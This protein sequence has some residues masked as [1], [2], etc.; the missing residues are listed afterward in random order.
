MSLDLTSHVS[1]FPDVQSGGGAVAMAVISEEEFAWAQVTVPDLA[2]HAGYQEWLDC[3]EGFQ[4]GLAMAGVEVKTVSVVL[5]PFLAW[6]RLTDSPPSEQ[7]LDLFASVILVLRLPPEPAVL[8]LVREGD[9]EAHAADVGAFV[10]HISFE[11]W[12]EHRERIGEKLKAAG[13]RVEEL[14]IRVGDFIEWGRCLGESSGEKALDAY[15][16]LVLEYLTDDYE[17]IDV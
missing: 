13:V 7:A 14:P 11:R 12:R 8:A 9:F 10:R 3:R 6:C 4:M 1:A 15:A 5:S 2:Y 16:A 17:K